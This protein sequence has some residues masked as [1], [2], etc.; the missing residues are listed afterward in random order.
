MKELIYNIFTF[1]L[2]PILSLLLSC[3]NVL[4]EKVYV[5]FI[6]AFFSVF[7]AFLPPV[8]DAYRYRELYYKTTFF[9][10]DF[11]HLWIKDKDFLFTF[12]SSIFNGMG[13]TFEL[14]KLF[15]LLTSYMLYC[16]MFLDIVKKNPTLFN[17]K[18]FFRLSVLSLFFS[19]RL[20]TLTSGIRFGVASTIIIIAIYLWYKKD[21]IKSIA[22]FV[23]S[24]TMHFSMLLFLP[25]VIGAILLS[26]FKIPPIV[27]GLTILILLITA[28]TS[29]GNLLLYLFPEN[30]LISGSVSTYI[31]GHWGTN[32]ILKTA[33]FGGL[34]FTFV[35][36]LPVIPLAY[37]VL[38]KK[39]TNPFL[40]EACFLLLLLLSIS[41]SSLTLLLRYS[42][43]AIAILFVVLLTT[44]KDDKKSLKEIKTALLSFMIMFGCY[45]YTQR[46]SLSQFLL[47]YRVI[48][49][50][51]TL[52]GDYTY[53]DEWVQT[54]LDFKGEYR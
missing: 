7:G 6:G 46:D 41:V 37:I 38:K 43:V 8:S 9:S 25:L 52:I 33:S 51:I 19:I 23:L 30:N 26:K 34:I 54:H 14:F 44:L 2:S 15:L 40:S 48:L 50:P 53:T 36:I 35:R 47:Q 45:A 28:Q 13:V 16:W 24:V 31:D 5:Y 49:S 22:V 3:K 11:N 17:S 42:N 12:L 10:F 32:A 20:F 21:Y 29:I 27:K 1:I 39:D 4:T 18:R